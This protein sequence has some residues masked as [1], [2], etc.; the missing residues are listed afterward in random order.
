MKK[1]IALVALSLCTA[2]PSF[3]AEHVLTHS[4]KVAAKDSYKAAKFSAKATDRAGRDSVKAA[5]FSAKETGRAG[6]TF[7]KLF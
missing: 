4:G 2:A 1:L 3:G 5:K 6:K 7:V